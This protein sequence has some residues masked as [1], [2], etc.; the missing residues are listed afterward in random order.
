MMYYYY[1][2]CNWENYQNGGEVLPYLNDPEPLMVDFV[3][4]V[5]LTVM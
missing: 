4:W 1:G 2:Q 5:R 3:V